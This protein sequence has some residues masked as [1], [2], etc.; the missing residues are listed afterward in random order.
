MRRADLRLLSLT[1]PR[2]IASVYR[3]RKSPYTGYTYT[4]FLGTIHSEMPTASLWK[5]FR[6]MHTKHQ[7]QL[8]ETSRKGLTI[9]ERRKADQ[10]EQALKPEDS[11]ENTLEKAKL[12]LPQILNDKAWSDQGRI[13]MS[14]MMR[15]LKV[16]QKTAYRIRR[17]LLKD[18]HQQD[19]ARAS[20]WGTDTTAEKLTSSQQEEKT[21]P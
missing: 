5:E 13:N 6:R 9:S 16:S 10:L 18:Y 12:I 2:A 7:E 19:S 1:S 21:P 8:Y 15:F 20:Q 17:E 4:P 14:D 3:I 11:F